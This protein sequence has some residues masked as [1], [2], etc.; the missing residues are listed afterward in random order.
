M[1][2]DFLAVDNF[3][4]TREIVTKNEKLVKMC[5]FVKIEFLDKNLTF[6]I[7]CANQCRCTFDLTRFLTKKIQNSN[8]V[9]FI[10]NLL[11][12][13]VHQT[14]IEC[15]KFERS[16]VKIILIFAPKIGIHRLNSGLACTVHFQLRICMT[17]SLVPG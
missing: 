2:L 13:P 7:V 5:F 15:F 1:V 11:G 4:F 14:S 9:I 8:F 17:K 6:R 10:Q 3:D 12:H 16:N